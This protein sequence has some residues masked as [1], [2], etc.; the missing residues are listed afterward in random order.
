[1]DVD[2]TTT[3]SPV[4]V[5]HGCV[6]CAVTASVLAV[7]PNP[8]TDDV[9]VAGPNGAAIPLHGTLYTVLGSVR[10]TLR[11]QTALDLRHEPAG[12]YLL[13]LITEQ[14]PVTLRVVKE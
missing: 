8:A 10:Q 2:G 14:G 6:N 3:Y 4:A 13:R 12:V 9:R 7:V 11:G 5:V 1:V